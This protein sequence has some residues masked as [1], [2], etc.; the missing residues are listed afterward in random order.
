MRRGGNREK[1]LTML[2]MRSDDERN[3]EDLNFQ[4]ESRALD[5]MTWTSKFDGVSN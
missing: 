1:I 4:L 2:G 5:V 3:D